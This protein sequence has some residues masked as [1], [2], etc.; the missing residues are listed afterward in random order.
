MPR[1]GVYIQQKIY[2]MVNN[3]VFEMLLDTRFP[4]DEFTTGYIM[5][6]MVDLLNC[7]RSL[8]L[9]KVTHGSLNLLQLDGMI[10]YG[11][12]RIPVSICFLESYP[13][14][15]PNV[16]VN[17]TDDSIIKKDISCVAS[18]GESF[19]PSLQDWKFHSSNVVS[20]VKNSDKF[21][22]TLPFASSNLYGVFIS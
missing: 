11:I 10:Q 12:Y 3:F 4:Y 16:R 15:R 7:D 19:L 18:S 13:R 20:L 9:K 5:Q 2:H 21:A 14:R 17:C 8:Q 6:H 1:L 22:R